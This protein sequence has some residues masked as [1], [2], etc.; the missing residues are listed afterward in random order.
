ML[1]RYEKSK[2]ARQEVPWRVQAMVMS[3]TT[4]QP[5]MRRKGAKTEKETVK[6]ETKGKVLCPMLVV[7]SAANIPFTRVEEYWHICLEAR[8]DH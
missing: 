7:T 2:R 6:A 3:T 1:I 5:A 8:N 4:M